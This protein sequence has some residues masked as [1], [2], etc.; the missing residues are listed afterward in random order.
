MK[1]QAKFTLKSRLNSFYFAF[2]GLKTVFNEEANFRIHLIAAGFAV[3]LGLLLKITKFE[4]I[5]IVFAIGIVFVS[6]IINS[7]IERLAD[8]ISPEKNQKIKKLKDLSAAA[9]LVSAITALIIGLIIFLPK[10]LTIL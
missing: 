4:W 2:S 10:L 9:V 6:E 8:I 5:S 1:K 3:L 7:S